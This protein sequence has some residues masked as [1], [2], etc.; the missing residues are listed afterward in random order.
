[1]GNTI[2]VIGE[3]LHLNRT[4][5]PVPET[6]CRNVSLEHGQRYF[7]RVVATHGAIPPL[8]SETRSFGFRTDD[9]PPIPGRVSL[10]LILPRQ[11][12][13]QRSFPENATGIAVRVRLDD[14]EDQESGIVSY[15]VA[16][17]ADG[18][19]IASVELVGGSKGQH[20]FRDL[21]SLR[22]GTIV[23]AIALPS[24]GARIQGDAISSLE[25]RLILGYISLAEP[26]FTNGKGEPHVMSFL[27]HQPYSV[28]FKRAHDPMDSNAEFDYTWFFTESPCEDVDG[29]S[30][31][32]VTPPIYLDRRLISGHLEQHSA[33][34]FALV[35]RNIVWSTS[36]KDN[37]LPAGE[38]CVTVS[39]CTSAERCANATSE[40]LLLDTSR[41]S[42]AVSIAG[43]MNQS[44][45]ASPLVVS[46]S[47][48]DSDSGIAGATL[49][50]GTAADPAQ[51]L[52]SVQFQV[53]TKSSNVSSE[54][55]HSSANH[56]HNASILIGIFET[57]TSAAGFTAIAMVNRETQIASA[58]LREPMVASVVCENTVRLSMAASNTSHID[59]NPPILPLQLWNHDIL[60]P[61]LKWSDK[62]GAWVGALDSLTTQPILE[63]L[64]VE[65]VSFDDFS[66]L[67]Y[68]L[69]VGL[70]PQGCEVEQRESYGD[71]RQA[72]LLHLSSHAAEVNSSS[73][74][75]W[76]TVHAIDSMGL[77]SSTETRVLIDRSPPQLGTLVIEVRVDTFASEL[78]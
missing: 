27:D 41:P 69:C 56:A 75:Y 29:V 33:D 52:D 18:E 20:L 53:G 13:K 26:W 11:I 37:S 57:E 17:Y 6:V 9:T 28:S 3:E 51:F 71:T 62:E 42:A 54:S 59:V 12:E 39:A 50:L 1:M 60:L 44:D 76:I 8:R 19:E 47:C 31:A 65:W 7:S 5:I 25:R 48:M 78:A 77:T 73:I 10:T 23:H 38:Y 21:G 32:P 67:H 58:E 24:N 55:S 4:A 61:A 30:S 74:V 15:A 49:S 16:L 64:A 34:M 70:Q 40:P 35:T 43:A 68:L 22:N 14:F 66:S 72:T 2:E 45:F 36:L 46:F 63:H